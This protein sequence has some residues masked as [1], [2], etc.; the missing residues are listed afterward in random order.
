MFLFLGAVGF[1]LTAYDLQL[2]L[3]I[4]RHTWTR[5]WFPRGGCG[6]ARGPLGPG[7]GWL[8]FTA[9]PRLI[10]KCLRASISQHSLHPAWEPPP[11][12]AAGCM[13]YTP[14]APSAPSVLGAGNW[15]LFTC[16]SGALHPRYPPP[17][18]R[19]WT[20]TSLTPAWTLQAFSALGGCKEHC[21]EHCGEH[22]KEHCGRKLFC[23]LPP[24]PSTTLSSSPCPFRL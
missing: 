5:L 11:K 20:G 19:V 13:P 2:P 9:H 12:P 4:A 17:L 18:A 22:C 24:H 14:C 3:C 21:G 6:G 16:W 15:P 8:P 7:F 23:A 10:P 1:P